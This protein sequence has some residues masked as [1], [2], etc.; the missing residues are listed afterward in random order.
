MNTPLHPLIVHFPIALLF[1]AAIVQI[2]ALWRPKMFDWP[3]NALLG[4]GFISGILAYMTG[5]AGVEYAKNVFGATG[6][7][8]HKHENVAFFTLL[9]FGVLIALKVLIRLP[10]IKEHFAK[11]LRWI[12]PLLMIISLAGLVLIY[13]TGHYGGQIVYHN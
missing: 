11:G 9:V 2:L 4:L 12:T 5:D 10:W 3:A 8:I 1:L 13:F 7:M 6:A